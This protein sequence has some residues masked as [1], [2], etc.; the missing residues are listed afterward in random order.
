MQ[1]K[2]ARKQIPAVFR[3]VLRMNG[4][5]D[6]QTNLDLGGGPYDL[7]TE[8][9]ADQGVRNLVWD[10]YNRS[11]T[12]NN[13]VMTELWKGKCHT[14]TISNVLNVVESE[15]H[16]RRLLDMAAQYVSGVVYI[17]VY[18][19]DKSGIGGPTRCGYQMNR[20]LS[21]YIDE[22]LRSFK[23]IDFHD[24]MVLAYPQGLTL[25]QQM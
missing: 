21:G 17:T 22:I 1:D 20:R 6:G 5:L 12:H 19:G 10:P 7:F 2:T 4:W 18:E 11:H 14:G 13:L 23:C 3:K 24:G 25:K 16:R 9:L 8:A 15:T